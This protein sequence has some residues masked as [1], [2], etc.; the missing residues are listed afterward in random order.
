MAGRLKDYKK[1]FDDVA[2]GRV[3]PL[4]FIHGPE[5]HMKKEFTRR[6]IE[7]VLPEGDRTFNLD[8]LHGDEFDPV[9]F[10]DRLQ[11]FPLFAKRRV[12]ILRN[13]DSLAVSQRERVVDVASRVPDGVT[14]V[15][16]SGA[17]KLETVAHKKLADVANKNGVAFAFATLDETETLERVL[18]RFRKEGVAIDQE[19]LD[20]LVE[21]VGTQMIDLSNEIDKLLLSV[22]DDKRITRELVASVVGKYR[23]ESL[24][25]LL[26]G[27]GVSA[28]ANTLARV[29]SLVEA[30]EEP[31][32][33]VSMLLRRTVNLL[34]VQSITQERGRAVGS[35][36]ALAGAIASTQSAFFAG[37]LRAQAARVSP[38]SLETL[39]TNLRWADLR[40]K[41]SALDARTVVEE[42]LLASHAGKRLASPPFAA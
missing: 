39:L 38:A 11:A 35:D 27:L 7:A 30:G 37:R 10:D 12:V 24:F 28:P 14:L 32:M 17:E 42:A 13:F 18:A 20:L 2:A 19:A 33:L 29:S 25:S 31:V 22:E 15:V 40:L 23:V 1:L 6:L 9:A 16:E 36:Q 3:K 8:I 4:Y 41:T 5:E 26:D 21:S 34:E